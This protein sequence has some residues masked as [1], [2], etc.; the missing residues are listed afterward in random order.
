MSVCPELEDEHNCQ[1]NTCYNGCS[2]QPETEIDIQEIRCRFPNSSAQDLDYPE[3]NGYLRNLV[4][5]P[6]TLWNVGKCA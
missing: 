6:A 2:Y 3:E 5:H 4:K 1:Q